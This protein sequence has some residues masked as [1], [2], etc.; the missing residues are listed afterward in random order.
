MDMDTGSRNSVV[1][2]TAI[3]LG[4]L[5]R[6]ASWFAIWYGTSHVVVELQRI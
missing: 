1:Q 5:V 4:Y 6:E 2:G 3:W